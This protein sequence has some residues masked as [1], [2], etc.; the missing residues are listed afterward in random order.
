MARQENSKVSDSDWTTELADNQALLY[1][2]I[3]QAAVSYHDTVNGEIDEWPYCP[4]HQ[5]KPLT[6]CPSSLISDNPNKA[7]RPF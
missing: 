4:V 1:C 2:G 7:N 5:E 3:C 6:V